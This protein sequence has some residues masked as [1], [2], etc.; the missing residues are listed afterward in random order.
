MPPPDRRSR[1]RPELEPRSPP[2]GPGARGGLD[3]T[4]RTRTDRL[5]VYTAGAEGILRPYAR[6]N[7]TVTGKIVRVDGADEI[8]VA[9]IGPGPA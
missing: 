4:L 8:W 6:R 7:V 3:Y 1:P 2:L 9:T 5:P